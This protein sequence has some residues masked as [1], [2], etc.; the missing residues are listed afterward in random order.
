MSRRRGPSSRL[1]TL[2]DDA[3]IGPWARCVLAYP[4]QV[5]T[6]PAAS[7]DP[8]LDHLVRSRL[9]A[10]TA[11]Y[12][13]AAGVPLDD[14]HRRRLRAGAFA[15]ARLAAAARAG[16][17]R[18]LE[19]LADGGVDALVVKGPGIAA[20]YQRPA[21]RPYSD[22][23]LLVRPREFRRAARLL[24][25]AGW[26]ADTVA[27]RAYFARRCAEGVNLSRSGQ[28]RVDL[29]HHVPPWVWGSQ[30]DF[31]WLWARSE[32]VDGGEYS[33]RCAGTVDNLLIS[34]LHVISDRSAPGA[35][36]MAWQDLAELA[37]AVD[38]S[39][40]RDAARSRR[41]DGW[42]RELAAALPAPLGDPLAAAVEAVGAAAEPVGAVPHRHRLRLLLDR[43]RVRRHP[44]LEWLA[45]LPVSSWPALVAG[46][47]VP[48]ADFRAAR[49]SGAAAT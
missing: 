30:L 8:E 21:W 5:T 9:A 19:V 12:L 44:S 42:L 10:R 28:D 32:P 14:D 4:W 34:A 17:H 1:A 38:P 48:S 39:A 47:L 23:D 27:P 7:L 43:E 31:D 29:H 6:P 13:K 37:R 40:L 49:R 26:H 18:A 11:A 25:A 35:S 45:R 46:I 24:A 20:R 33:F 16:G 2:F 36:L 22:L 15:A 41:L 3:G